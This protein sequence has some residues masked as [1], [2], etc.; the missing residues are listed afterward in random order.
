MHPVG[1][2]LVDSE[3]ELT[4]AEL[5]Q[6]SDELGR[7]VY[8]HDALLVGVLADDGMADHPLVHLLRAGRGGEGRGGEGS[9]YPLIH[10]T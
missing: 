2:H 5:D 3:T 4:A 8:R 10:S 7:D 9:H 6:R 1:T